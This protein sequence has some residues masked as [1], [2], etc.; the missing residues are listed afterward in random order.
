MQ[1]RLANQWG[2]LGELQESLQGCLPAI[3]QKLSSKNQEHMA[4]FQSI[5]VKHMCRLNSGNSEGAAFL[6]HSLNSA[7]SSI[8]N[9]TNLNS[10]GPAK[11]KMVSML[12]QALHTKVDKVT[13]VTR[14]LGAEL[15]PESDNFIELVSQAVEREILLQINKLETFK[16]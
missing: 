11:N 7:H 16:A 14:Q 1:Q 6:N 3:K 2:F 15:Q 10:G 5:V 9:E 13:Q 8:E 4:I 12:G